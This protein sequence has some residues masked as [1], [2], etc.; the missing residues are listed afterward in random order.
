M[1]VLVNLLCSSLCGGVE[2]VAQI[3]VSGN[4]FAIRR[5]A[6]DGA[7]IKFVA[8][9]NN[10]AKSPT[11][12]GRSI[13]AGH[14]RTTV[15]GVHPRYDRVAKMSEVTYKGRYAAPGERTAVTRGR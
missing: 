11:Y 9:D 3:V 13:D 4:V 12:R 7:R 6:Q 14:R 5:L 2:R 15:A 8:G 10:M 1:A